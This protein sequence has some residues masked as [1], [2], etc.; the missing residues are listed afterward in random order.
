MQ[1][2]NRFDKIVW[3]VL[4]ALVLL[5]AVTLALGDRVGVQLK[6][7]FPLGGGAHSTDV[8]LLEFTELMARDTVEQRLTFDPP[9]EGGFSWSG[10]TAFFRPSSAL[11]AGQTYTARLGAGATSRNGREVLQDYEFSFTV[12]SPLVAY[13]SPADGFPQNIWIA[14]PQNPSSAEQVTFSNAGIFDFAVSPNGRSIVFSE[15]RT[16]APV[17]DLKLLD[18]DTREVS[19]L[20]D[21]SDA[22]CSSPTWRPDGNVIAYTRVDMNSLLP[23]IGVSPSRIWLLDL[24]TNPPTTQPLFEDSQTLGYGPQW[25][26]NGD[27]ITLFDS[28]VPGVL[29]YSFS[30][31][32][33]RVIESQH[34][35]SGVLSPTGEYLIYPEIVLDGAR[36]WSR[37]L[38]ANLD[39]QELTPLVPVEEPVEDNFAV[40][41]PSGE[42]VLTG[43]RYR[44]ERMTLSTQLFLVDIESG[45]GEPLVFDERYN[46]GFVHWDPSGNQIVMQR[47]QQFT[48]NGEPNRGGRPEIWVY[49]LQ[50]ETLTQV[51]TNGMFPRWVP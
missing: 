33:L 40:W 14:D 15:R 41:H 36:A 24:T 30:Q 11:L 35:T 27:R 9:I 29:V 49:D 23:D 46:H 32:Q 13:L 21:C 4:A 39:T 19:L 51:A 7:V 42:S 20:L 48:D 43:R 10:A 6:R 8:I 44:D 26:A 45:T 12:R 25:S 31:N 34:G 28:S 5:I 38:L 2:I 50:T 22:D 3:Q 47:F 1:P 16:D 37:L 18:L 17:T